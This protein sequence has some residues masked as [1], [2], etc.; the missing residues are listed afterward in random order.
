MRLSQILNTDE[1]RRLHRME[2]NVTR[3]ASQGRKK[4]PN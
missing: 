2:R 1:E 3:E 4:N